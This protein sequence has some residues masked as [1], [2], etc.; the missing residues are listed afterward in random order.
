MSVPARPSPPSPRAVRGRKRA[1]LSVTGPASAAVAI[2]CVEQLRATGWHIPD[3][4]V[5]AGLS[6]VRWPAR[7]E[8]LGERPLVVLDCA[9][10]VASAEALVGSSPRASA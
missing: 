7:L 3:P 1:N 10:N 2:A 4:A 9:H 8:L 6:G 5:A